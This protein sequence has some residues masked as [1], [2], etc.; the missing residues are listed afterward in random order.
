MGPKRRNQF[1]SKHVRLA[2]E[3]S[4]PEP[5]DGEFIVRLVRSRGGNTMVRIVQSLSSCPQIR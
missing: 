1:A 3:Q 5:A 2:A 4:Y